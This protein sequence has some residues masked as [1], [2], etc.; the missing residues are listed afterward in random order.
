MWKD[1]VLKLK[2][3]VKQILI[4]IHK[5]E[6]KHPKKKVIDGNLEMSIHSTHTIFWK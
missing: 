2:S 4:Y 6:Y 5:F 3:Q 1:V